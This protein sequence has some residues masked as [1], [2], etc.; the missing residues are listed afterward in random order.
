[1]NSRTL[2]DCS[3]LLLMVGGGVFLCGAVTVKAII[4]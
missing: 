2:L 4:M 1:M 3:G